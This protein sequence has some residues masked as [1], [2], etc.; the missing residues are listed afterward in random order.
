MHF[1]I[2]YIYIYIYIYIQ[3]AAQREVSID[4]LI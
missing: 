2:I 4:R 1:L 3:H